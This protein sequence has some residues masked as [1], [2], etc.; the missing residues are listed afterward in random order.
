MCLLRFKVSAALGCRGDA[1]QLAQAVSKLESIVLFSLLAIVLS[2][3]IDGKSGGA[4]VSPLNKKGERER[5][6][7]L[8]PQHKST[9]SNIPNHC[10]TV[11]IV[12]G[13]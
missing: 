12:L 3:A 10:W 6:L 8:S 9:I 2:V 1:V 13:F 5:A 4:L 11:R 7:P